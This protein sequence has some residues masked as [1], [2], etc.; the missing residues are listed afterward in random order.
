MSASAKKKE[1]TKT[2]RG[3]DAAIFALSKNIVGAF[4]IIAGEVAADRKQQM[5]TA[6]N[7]SE[8]IQL[9]ALFWQLQAAARTDV[10]F[11]NYIC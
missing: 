11:N 3:D 1:T 5:K 10:A 2:L 7:G 8:P 9:V 4:V 6:T